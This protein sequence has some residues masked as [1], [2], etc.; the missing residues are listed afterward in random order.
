[1]E[2]ITKMV[3]KMV[4][5]I[6][7]RLY[8]SIGRQFG[9]LFHCK[10]NIQD[11]ADEVDKL[12]RV[13]GRVDTKVKEALNNA[14]VIEDDVS[15]WQTKM[16]SSLPTMVDDMNRLLQG[17]ENLR[18]LD[19][20]LRYRLGKEGKKKKT[21][22]TKLI[23]EGNFDS[24]A[25]QPPLTG[26]WRS[27]SMK[28]ESFESRERVFKQIMEALKDD[29]NYK[30]GI[31]GMP[32]V[33]KTRMMK[34]V[35]EQA[36][37]CKLF[38]EI[39]QVVVTQNPNLKEIQQKLA[40]GLNCNLEEETEDARKGRLYLRLKNG[41]KI[42]VMV[43]DVWNDKIKLEGIGIPATDDHFTGCKILL[44]SRSRD[45]CKEMGVQ[46]KGNFQIGVLSDVEA[47]SLF[48][49]KVGDS[50][51]THEMQSVAEEVCRECACLPLAILAVGGALQNKSKQKWKDALKQLRNCRA[52]NI[53]G[54][55]GKLYSRIELSYDYLESIDAKSI[56]LLCCLFGED[57][58]I[59]IDD[60]VM[61]GVGLR[62]LQGVDTMEEARNRTHAIV[63]T[64]K[65][66][67]LLLEGKSENYVK[68]HD[69][70]RDVAI[71][72]ASKGEDGM[73][74]VKAGVEKWPEDD[75]YKRC[76]A[77]SLRLS[78]DCVLPDNS[79]Y[80]QL[81]TLMLEG[82]Y[83]SPTIPSNF[84]KGMEKLEVLH[85]RDMGNLTVPSS[86]Q[87]LRMLRLYRCKLVNLAFLKELRKLE[88]LSIQYPS[89]EEWTLDIGQL[90][91]LRS[92]DVRGFSNLQILPGFISSL[93]QL[94]EFH[95]RDFDQW[96]IEGNA[97]L[98]ELNSLTRLISLQVQVPNVKL[99]PINELLSKSLIRF[100]ISIG[101]GLHF[102]GFDGSST[103][104][105]ILKLKGIPL[106]RELHILME[107]AEVLHLEELEIL[108]NVSQ[109]TD[110]EGFLDL[111]YLR[112]WDCKGI[113][114]LFG[115]PNWNSQTIGSRVSCSFSK[116]S[117]L[118]VF[119][120]PSRY[121][122]SAAAAR[123]LLQLQE[124]TISYCENL[125][126][127]VGDDNEIMDNVVT[128]HQLKKMRLEDLPKLRSFNANTKKTS[129]EE[130][131]V[132]GLAQ[133]FN[134]KVKFPA[135][136][137]LEIGGLESL[138]AIWDNQLFL[139]SQAEDSFRQLRFIEVDMC[140]KLVN[141][142]PPNVL[143]LLQKLESLIVWSCD[144]IVSGVEV[145]A[146]EEGGDEIVMFPQ[147]KTM[148]LSNLPKLCSF[149]CSGGSKEEEEASDKI[150]VF[151]QLNKMKLSSLPKFSSFCCF[152][153]E[154]E[155]I[156]KETIPQRDALFNQKVQFPCLEKLVIERMN[157]YR[158]LKLLNVA[159]TESLTSFQN[160][161][162]LRVKECDSL[163]EVF[164]V[165]GSKGAEETGASH[166]ALGK[167]VE[168][169]LVFPQLNEVVFNNL[170]SLTSFCGR[171]CISELPSVIKI[172]VERCPKLEM[173][174]CR[175]LNSTEPLPNEMVEFPILDRLI[176][177]D[178]SIFE[179][180]CHVLPFCKV[181]KSLE[182]NNCRN[183]VN[184]YTLLQRFET[185]QLR[186]VYLPKL[187][188]NWIMEPQ[189]HLVF[190]NL[191]KLTVEQ[192]ELKYLFSLSIA[193]SLTQLRDL[194]IK[195]CGV[196]E[197]ILKNE[198]QDA[199]DEIVF[200]QLQR[201]IV[202]NCIGLKYL[203]SLSIAKSLT[204]LRD[205]TIENCGVM[206]EIL[207]NEGGGGGENA[208]DEIEFSQLGHLILS[209][210]PNLTC[211]CQA[212]NAFK[213]P[214]LTRVDITRCPELKTFTSGYLSTPDIEVFKDQWKLSRVNDLN[215][216]VQQFWE[217]KV[218]KGVAVEDNNDAETS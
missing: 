198:E 119:E 174:P 128:F 11:Y 27:N 24:F 172:T 187:E 211:F 15:Q 166:K 75:E 30:I 61:Y 167:E 74:I 127:I 199:T 185:T 78:K 63:D 43:D 215:N 173:F 160:L 80:P 146:I 110:G 85:L 186:L 111:K 129:A 175:Y 18:C 37:K 113:E 9:Y 114:H 122:F 47:W 33:G 98:V 192:L 131:N 99:L 1:M 86:L 179:G 120:C 36:Q 126:E 143:P 52:D 130:C 118:R 66:S 133:L 106:K 216:H 59:F 48:K 144:S 191:T 138:T 65:I 54:L 201:L 207:K 28:Y 151:P 190:H 193:K 125:E 81:R 17:K 210:L 79:E 150:L 197:E 73:F 90:T 206:E 196:M 161:K 212:N 109:D 4:E 132:S 115:R 13:K 157:E 189:G 16:Q 163:E 108:K 176:L 12:R 94:E 35:A 142:I 44:T 136:E 139:G 45:V 145:V 152:R 23:E 83:R 178:E 49:K 116:L 208:T 209:Y 102:Y 46:E 10:Q 62:L 21:D 218:T 32:G 147:L 154:K 170:P 51:E 104:T 155:S 148:E 5:P 217:G 162:E 168:N 96:E 71:S 31:H 72:I 38:D 177:S 156:L 159:S 184:V 53:G 76:R 188:R 103:A 101:Q 70:I 58:E 164:K 67:S 22:V 165:K 123:G 2:V 82:C 6:I 100:Q 112:V 141:V 195:Y 137:L 19:V 181:P 77:I 194:R 87:N 26:I 97:S 40:E 117:I 95:I 124:L 60:L 171:N 105:R 140:E 88:I 182:V 135:L 20:C 8:T 200:S 149:C 180:T 213:F 134:D 64:L 183:L 14:Q 25:H 214:S 93:S 57:A 42:L 153:N 69:V 55:Q 203:F 202:K 39:A 91:S 169:N 7:G 68:M 84:F 107:K 3:E 92:L 204:Q 50:F 121:L 158:C 56:F 29:S 89:L 34:E 205:L 41:K